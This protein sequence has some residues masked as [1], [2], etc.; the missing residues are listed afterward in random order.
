MRSSLGGSKKW[1]KW[2]GTVDSCLGFREQNGK[3]VMNFIP[4]LFEID[5]QV[6]VT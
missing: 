6:D 1:Q 3:L 4:H 5:Q 2:K